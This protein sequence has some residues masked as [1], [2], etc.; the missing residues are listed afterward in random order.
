MV[1]Y[2]DTIEKILMQLTRVSCIYVVLSNELNSIANL[3]YR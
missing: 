3:F 1:E 2:N